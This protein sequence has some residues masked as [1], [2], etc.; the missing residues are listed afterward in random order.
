MQ[1][2]LLSLGTSIM[3]QSMEI[4]T[5]GI[6]IRISDRFV[7]PVNWYT[8]CRHSTTGLEKPLK[9]DPSLLG[10]GWVRAWSIVSAPLK[11]ESSRLSRSMLSRKPTSIKLT[12]EDLQDYDN[13]VSAQKTTSSQDNDSS[14]QPR[15]PRK[16]KEVAPTPQDRQQTMDDRIGVTT[17]TR[18]ARR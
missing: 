4:H 16:G 17:A 14:N 10:N 6:G 2:N 11:F 1:P 12:Q 5:Y 9:L 8:D 18:P 15:N 13:L 7:G 3:P